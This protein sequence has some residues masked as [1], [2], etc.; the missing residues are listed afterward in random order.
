MAEL[1]VQQII[2]LAK[3]E[4]Y[5][6]LSTYVFW[7]PSIQNCICCGMK[8]KPYRFSEYPERFMAPVLHIPWANNSWVLRKEL[9]ESVQL[10]ETTALDGL[11][12]I[13]ER[14]PGIVAWVNLFTLRVA[15]MLN[16]TRIVEKLV[17]IL[18]HRQLFFGKGGEYGEWAEINDIPHE[19]PLIYPAPRE[20]ILGESLEPHVLRCQ[21]RQASTMN[22]DHAIEEWDAPLELCARVLGCNVRHWETELFESYFRNEQM[23]QLQY[24]FK[25]G[26]YC[27]LDSGG[28]PRTRYETI[29]AKARDLRR[30]RL[31]GVLWCFVRLHT[32]LTKHRFYS[33]GGKYYLEAKI[34]FE[35][36]IKQNE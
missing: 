24:V 36:A 2:R 12:L 22:I 23:R 6:I 20:A 28:F 14:Y 9:K 25:N 31:C 34:R 5:G 27:M 32:I 16:W 18:E 21:D 10:S 8:Q 13:L 4:A 33:P 29:I 11:E 15:V 3:H 17:H 7:E 19:I 30:V 35:M 26:T 1:Y